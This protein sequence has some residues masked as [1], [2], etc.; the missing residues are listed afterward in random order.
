[1]DKAARIKAF[2]ELERQ[3][4]VLK[5]E[6]VT[7]LFQKLLKNVKIEYKKF[8]KER[9]PII[10]NLEIDLNEGNGAV[11]DAG[12][13]NNRGFIDAFAK[14]K[15]DHELPFS[16]SQE[17]KCE[18]SGD[19][20]TEVHFP[21]QLI[22]RTSYFVSNAFSREI[23]FQIQRQHKIF[24]MTFGA[25]PGKYSISDQRFEKFYKFV[26]IKSN[27]EAEAINVERLSFFSLKDCIKD[28]AVLG[29]FTARVPNRKKET[30]PDVIEAVVDLQVA[31]LALLLDAVHLPEHHTALHRRTAP[32]QLAVITEGNSKD[33]NDLARFVEL[34]VTETEPRIETLRTTDD[35]ETLDSIGIPYAIILD[36]KALESGLFKLRSR[37]TTLS[38][39]IHLSDVNNYL[40]KIFNA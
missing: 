25:S 40:V 7:P 3:N 1:M 29:N 35:F 32:Y 5:V 30:V 31:S 20:E 33:L 13:Y 27:V 39:T 10:E 37:N 9:K 12:N 34:L 38:E 36:E 2:V 17:I 24:W 19:I 15:E 23:F 28:K 14:A 26:T 22:L 18:N 4:N 21:S 8:H 11:T 6:K 16:I